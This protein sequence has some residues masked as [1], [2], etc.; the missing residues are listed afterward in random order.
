MRQIQDDQ[1]GE[2]EFTFGHIRFEILNRSFNGV[3]GNSPGWYLK[4]GHCQHEIG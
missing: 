3:K 4:F 2:Q 1:R